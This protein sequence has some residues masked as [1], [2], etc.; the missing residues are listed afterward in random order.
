VGVGI[1]MAKLVE[2]PALALRDRLFPPRSAS[3]VT[4]LPENLPAGVKERESVAT[5]S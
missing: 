3:P 2:M 1:I 4:P 5:P